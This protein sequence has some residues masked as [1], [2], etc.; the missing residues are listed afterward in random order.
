MTTET[1]FKQLKNKEEKIAMITC[2][3]FP[4]AKIL[5]QNHIDCILVG[6]SLGTNILGYNS[7]KEVTLNDIIHHTKAVK[8]GAPN[9]LI[10][11][12]LPYN[13]YSSPKE[14]LNTAQQLIKAGASGIKFE[15]FFPDILQILKQHNIITVCH[16]GLLPQTAQIKKL[17][18]TSKEEVNALLQQTLEC[19]KYGADA[20]ILELIP[21]EAAQFITEKVNIPT[22]GIGAGRFCDGQVQIINDIIGFPHQTFKHIAQ[23]DNVE[24]RLNA[25]ISSYIHDVKENTLLDESNSFHIKL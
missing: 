18:S 20:L 24:N 15:G 21:E 14:A 23:Y 11:S 9:S 25:T 22:I 1:L 13:T 19:E 3:D 4:T 16:L 12:D 10:I 5:D 17:Q 2:Y 6:D 7:E 8:R